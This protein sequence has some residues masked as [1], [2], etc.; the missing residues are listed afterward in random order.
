MI[1]IVVVI[2]IVIAPVIV[3]ALLIGNHAVAVI[4]ARTSA[5]TAT[6]AP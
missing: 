4:N 3:A 2:V 5:R 6:V 1:V